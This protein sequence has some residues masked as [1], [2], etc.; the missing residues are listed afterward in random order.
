MENCSVECDRGYQLCSFK[1]MGYLA[2]FSLPGDVPQMLARRAVEEA[3]MRF[4]EIDRG[5]QLA[6]RDQQFVVYRAFLGS[7]G[8]LSITQHVVNGV[9]RSYLQFRKSTQLS[10]SASSTKGQKELYSVQVI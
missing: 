1:R 5:P 10:K 4:R 9:S 6:V 8:A 7:L 3:L 2:V